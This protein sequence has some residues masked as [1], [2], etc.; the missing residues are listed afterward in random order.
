MN[1]FQARMNSFQSK[2]VWNEFIPSY[3]WNQGGEGRLPIAENL[4]S[5]REIQS[6]FNLLGQYGKIIIIII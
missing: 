2:F 3:R 4:R 5:S 6:S 1:L